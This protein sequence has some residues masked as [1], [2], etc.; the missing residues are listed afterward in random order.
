MDNICPSSLF[1]LYSTMIWSALGRHLGLGIIGFTDFYQQNTQKIP[2]AK[3]LHQILS[4]RIQFLCCIKASETLHKRN[5]QKYSKIQLIFIITCLHFKAVT[6]SP[7]NI[8]LYAA[9]FLETLQYRIKKSNDVENA[10]KFIT[11]FIL[12]FFF[13]GYVYFK[14]KNTGDLLMAIS[15]GGNHGYLIC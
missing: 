14:K 5:Q 7:L 4:P 11:F 8:L 10:F 1:F 2:S 12:F 13:V 6:F 9:K 15:F 3:S